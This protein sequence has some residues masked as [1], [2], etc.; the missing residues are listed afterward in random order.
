[1]LPRRPVHEDGELDASD[2]LLQV[3]NK[4]GQRLFTVPAVAGDCRL[5][6]RWHHMPTCGWICHGL[7]NVQGYRG[8]GNLGTRAR[9]HRRRSSQDIGMHSPHNT[10]PRSSFL[11]RVRRPLLTNC[12]SGPSDTA[13]G[14]TAWQGASHMSPTS[15][16]HHPSQPQCPLY[17]E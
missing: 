2:M 13:I 9:H 8:T 1:M 11:Q 7:S 15:R 17:W 12:V 3:T 5:L 16:T 14:H 10:S 4:R 6:V